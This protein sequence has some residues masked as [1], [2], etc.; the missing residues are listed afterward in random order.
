MLT[1]YYTDAGIRARLREYCGGGPGSAP[2]AV[3][4]A[5]VDPGVAGGAARW[6]LA[7]LAPIARLD[8]LAAAGGDLARSLWDRDH[9]LFHLDLDYQN[10]D[11]PGEPFLYP[12]EA[13][14]RLEAVYRAVRRE[15]VH[16]DLPLF[17]IMTGRGYHF[18][19]Q[20]GLDDPLI[21]DLAALASAPPRWL[22]GVARRLPSG[23]DAS[24]TE[25]HA[26]A[27]AGLACLIE[28]L[29]HR[30]IRRASLD[31]PIPVVCNGTI[32]GTGITGRAAAS[33][34]F[35]H[36]GDPLDVRLIR[37]AFSRYELHTLRADLVGE[38]AAATPVIAAVPRRRGLEE[39]LLSRDPRHALAA[40]AHDHPGRGTWGAPSLRRVPRLAAGGVSHRLLR[41]LRATG[42]IAASDRHRGAASVRRLATPRAERSP[43][44]AGVHPARDACAAGL[45]LARRRHRAAGLA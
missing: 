30:V 44:A 27:H 37:I 29:V 31:T 15:M 21:Q 18:T 3:Y 12:A 23:V 41:R 26:R 17:T 19:G 35:S 42:G 13:F 22:E 45:G 20:I 11:A 25:T 16:F 10:T 38:R 2:T 7:R 6:E 36:R 14:F 24:M 4:A 39:A 8:A 28:Y 5:G 34:D 32:V 43:A 33:L 1:G 9:L 40:A